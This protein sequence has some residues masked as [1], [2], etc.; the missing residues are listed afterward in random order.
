[1]TSTTKTVG[2]W[3]LILVVAVGLYNFVERSG[4][5]V[6][7]LNF[8]DLLT[9][10][11]RGAVS[12]VVITGSTVEGKLRAD[13]EP[14][15]STIPPNYTALYDKLTSMG[16]RVAVVPSDQSSWTIPSGW[17]AILIVAG[18]LLWFAISVIVLM[19]VL[20]LSRFVKRELTRTNGRPSAT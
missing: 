12:E 1:M 3:V 11:E 9:S 2:I 8:T 6:R 18:S 17:A 4:P 5:P 16:V 20:D 7:V 19:L 15:R 10:V 13:N 14:F